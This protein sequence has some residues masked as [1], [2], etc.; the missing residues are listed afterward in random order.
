ML[1]GEGA[2]IGVVVLAQ[3][4]EVRCAAAAAEDEAG[5]VLAVDLVGD[6]ARRVERDQA[7]RGRRKADGG[8]EF[9]I[10]AAELGDED[11]GERQRQRAIERRADGR[12]EIG[13]GV[14]DEQTFVELA[15]EGAG[16]NE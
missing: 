11:D 14:G 5:D 13:R 2:D 1:D 4:I 6:G 9:R 3:H 12:A 7:R 10:E 16:K 8:G 15:A